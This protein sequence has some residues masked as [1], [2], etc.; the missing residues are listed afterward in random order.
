M[1]TLYGGEWGVRNVRDNMGARGGKIHK[2]GGGER[3]DGHLKIQTQ[4]QN[5]TQTFGQGKRAVRVQIILARNERRSSIG[6]VAVECHF[7]TKE[8][9]KAGAVGQARRRREDL[10]HKRRARKLVNRE[11][12]ADSLENCSL[13]SKG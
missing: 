3:S 8:N 5:H 12:G 2:K 11:R 9:Q 6:F 4:K 7:T 1:R 13:R 10:V